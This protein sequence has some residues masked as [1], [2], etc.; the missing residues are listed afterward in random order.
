MTMKEK[1]KATN[2]KCVYGL[3]QRHPSERERKKKKSQTNKTIDG[4]EK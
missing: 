3:Q 1:D 4:G 2:K